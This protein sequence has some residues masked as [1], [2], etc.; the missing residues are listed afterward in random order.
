MVLVK[1]TRNSLYS[2]TWALLTIDKLTSFRAIFNVKTIDML[3][4]RKNLLHNGI[5]KSSI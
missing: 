4:Q 2:I 3:F 1:V 5:D